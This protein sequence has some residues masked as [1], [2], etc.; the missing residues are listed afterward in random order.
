MTAAN[1]MP[2][3]AKTLDPKRPTRHEFD[4]PGTSALKT[5]RWLPS[6]SSGPPVGRTV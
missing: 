4:R 1:P 6:I 5:W 3:P 2:R